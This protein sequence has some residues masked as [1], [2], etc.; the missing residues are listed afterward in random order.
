MIKVTD[1]QMVGIATDFIK[2]ADAD[3][4]CEIIEK[5]F[6]V[7]CTFNDDDESFEVV[8]T[9]DYCGAFDEIHLQ[10]MS[11]NTQKTT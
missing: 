10:T 1:E 7:K 4:L 5:M 3:D 11:L 9:D 8:P 6:G 2:H